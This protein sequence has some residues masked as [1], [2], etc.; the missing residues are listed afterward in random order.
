MSA[1]PIDGPSTQFYADPLVIST[2]EGESAF[3]NLV[4]V[5]G[6]PFAMEQ[7]DRPYQEFIGLVRTCFDPDDLAGDH[8]NVYLY[9]AHCLH[10]TVATFFPICKKA[11]MEGED[12]HLANKFKH[13]LQAASQLPEWPTQPLQFKLASTQLGTKAGILLWNELTGGMD[14]CG[15]VYNSKA[16]LGRPSGRFIISRTLSTPRF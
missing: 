1:I 15:S 2:Y 8:P 13:L 11:T 12:E 9:N 3:F 14:K 5:A 7:I 6:W 16:K 4:L 10:I